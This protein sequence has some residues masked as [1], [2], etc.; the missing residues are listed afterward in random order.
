MATPPVQVYKALV[1]ELQFHDHRYHVLDDPLIPDVE[2]DRKLM[3]LRLLEDTFPDL[4]DDNSPSQ[5][6]GGKSLLEFSQ[7]SHSLPM[8]SLENAFDSQALLNFDRRVAER[9]DEKENVNYVCEPKLDGVAL[10]LLYRN[11]VLESAG[12]RG[13]GTTGEDVTANARTI[14]SVPLRLQG[15]SPPNLIEVR[16]EVYIPHKGF[17]LLNARNQKDGEKTFVNPRNAAAGS[18]RQLDSKIWGVGRQS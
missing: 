3:Q 17:D 10:S 8:L 5:R 6:V 7:I 9:T 14:R 16:G 18:L 1:K 15:D 4:M 12:T 2:Y 11:G 13:D